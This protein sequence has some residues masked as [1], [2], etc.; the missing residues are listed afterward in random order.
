[1]QIDFE[2]RV[3]HEYEPFLRKAAGRYFRYYNAMECYATLEYDEF[4]QE[5]A[6]GLLK[7]VRTCED[8]ELPLQPYTIGVAR[9]YI[10]MHCSRHLIQ[11]A[12]GIHRLSRTACVHQEYP[13]YSV[14]YGNL[15]QFEDGC[16]DLTLDDV[17]LLATL[18]TLTPQQ[19]MIA[20]CL[21]N[22]YSQREIVRRKILP[23]RKL[24]QTVKMLR[25]IFS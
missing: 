17:E 11:R 15:E 14:P 2:T 3:L 8:Y 24:E 6:I 7:A 9:L 22:G 12:D 13:T 16:L 19:Q 21:I 20:K 23:R 5:A 18:S 4:Y 25:S 10:R 1:M